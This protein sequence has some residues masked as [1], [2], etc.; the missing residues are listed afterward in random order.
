MPGFQEAARRAPAD[1][2]GLPPGAH[3]QQM[4]RDPLAQMVEDLAQNAQTLGMIF[5]EKTRR[6]AEAAKHLPPD[7]QPLPDT[8]D[9]KNVIDAQA[10]A[11]EVALAYRKD[12]RDGAAFA[13][14]FK[15]QDKKEEGVISFGGEDKPKSTPKPAAPGGF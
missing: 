9:L 5:N 6:A 12:Q 13:S 8:T 11:I 7:Q 10:K 3:A 14:A 2:S 4:M 15:R 1:P